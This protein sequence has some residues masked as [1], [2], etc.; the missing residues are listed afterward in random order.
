MKGK[1]VIFLS[2]QTKKSLNPQLPMLNYE[3]IAENPSQFLSLTS[4]QLDEFSVLLKSF[5]EKWLSRMRYYTYSGKARQRAY[6]EKKNAKL[7][8]MEEKLFFIL[9]YLKNNPLQES[10]GATFGMTQP[11]ANGTISLYLPILKEA[12]AAQSVLPFE[13]VSQLG[14]YLQ[15]HQ[16]GVIYQDGTERRIE[17][18]SDYETQKEYYSGKKKQHSVKNNVIS[19][20]TAKILFISDTYEGKV[21][22]KKISDE[23]ELHLP[24]GTKVCQDTGFQGYTPKGEA[25]GVIMPTKK[26]RKKELSDEQKEENRQISKQRVKIEHSIGGVKRIRILKEE[27]RHK[28]HQI[29]HQVFLI[30][31]GLHNFRLKFRP[32]NYQTQNLQ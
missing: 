30:G 12:L 14:K 3:K 9:Y 11:Q 4:L 15:T 31:C 27:I 25:I 7:A 32:W 29:R 13:K 26:T 17:R 21:H 1:K 19:D 8:R 5:E 10:L 22:D 20:D 23:M 6:S 24:K 16:I 2:D 18:S 28:T